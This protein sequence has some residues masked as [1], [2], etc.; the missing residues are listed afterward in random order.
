MKITKDIYVFIEQRENK[1]LPVSFE[2]LNEANKL[3]AKVKHLNYHVVAVVLGYN[4]SDLTK[5]IIG[6]GADK[7]IV[8]DDELLEKYS[9]QYYCDVLSLVVNEYNPDSLLIGATVLGRDLAPRVSARVNTGLTADATMIN[10]CDEDSEQALLLVTRPAFGGNLYG[11]IVCPNTRPQMATIRPNVFEIGAFDKTKVGEVINFEVKITDL[12]QVVSTAITKK[13]I[14]G[15]NIASA[16]FII[17]VGRGMAKH[18]DVA[19][20]VCESLNAT[21]ACSRAIVDEGLAEK[22]IQVGQTGTTVRPNVY[23]ACGIS[24]AAQHIAGMENADYIIAI[25]T[26]PN[27]AIFSIANMG[28][29]GDASV[30]LKELKNLLAK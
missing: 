1:I 18:L 14:K 26:D 22:E 24:G 20:E 4:I 17:S 19:K 11:T 13:E 7:V 8:C 28:I 23:I 9:T 2:L 15:V 3:V 10:V 16:N 5:E 25:N 21:M 30:V 6:H 29:V 27:A 12:P